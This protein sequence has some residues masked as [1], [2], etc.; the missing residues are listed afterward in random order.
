MVAIAW[1]A[2]NM[3]MSNF[4]VRF[5]DMSQVWLSELR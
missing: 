1:T 5:A 2:I 3:L 4:M